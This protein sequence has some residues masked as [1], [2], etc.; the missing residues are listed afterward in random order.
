MDLPREDLSAVYLLLATLFLRE[1]DA[2]LL[3]QLAQPEIADVL[4]ML[5]P[6]TAAYLRETTWDAAALDDLAAEY[7]RL[8]L[9][10]KGVSPYAMAWIKGEEGALRARL[11]GE[12]GTLQQALRVRPDEM[13][14]GN[15]PADH[16]GMLLS[17]TAV[18]LQAE[19]D[20][21]DGGIAAR[22]IALMNDWAPRFCTALQEE[23]MSPLYRAAGG[24][25]AE[26]LRGTETDG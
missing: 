8:F 12:I 4:D 25:L 20:P 10:P 23:S 3:Q 14:F 18:A 1:A 17:L 15:V 16:I 24:L 21:S 22:V 2:E 6:G 26:L 7:A 11:G 13:G 5:E 19:A 9:L